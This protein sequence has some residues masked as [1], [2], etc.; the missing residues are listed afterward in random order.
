[1]DTLTI[2]DI[3]SAERPRERL[4]LHG[5]SA[6]SAVELIAI[7]LGAGTEGRSA[8][9]V[10]RDL[11]A[12]VHGSLRRIATQPL[13]ALT[14]VLGIGPTRAIT[15]HAALEL[16]RR[17]AGEDRAEG[18]PIQDGLDV[19]HLYASRLEDLPVEEFHVAT[20]DAQHRIQSD[21][22]V[23]RGTLNSA[24]AHPREVF[25]YAIAENAFAVIL[26]HNHPSG[27]P[28]PSPADRLM[29]TQIVLS[30][31]LLDIPVLDHVIVGRGRFTSFAERGILV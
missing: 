2:R 9:E 26:I 22:L 23:S 13:P 8:I 27:D 19:Y 11:L 21:V 14:A 17:M 3:P 16:G 7:L 6:L 1:M 12:S 18:I 29:T 24:L 25:R 31:Q 28:E 10:S 15:I 4:K 5:A 30:G 20:L